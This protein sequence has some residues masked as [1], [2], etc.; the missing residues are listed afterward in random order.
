MN[1][2]LK[3]TLIIFGILLGIVLLD[4]MQAK[5]FNNSPIIKITKT[6]SDFHKKDI[7]ILVETNIYEGVTKQTLFKWEATTIPIMTNNDVTEEQLNNVNDKIIKYFMSSNV[8]YDNL[9]FNY[10]DLTNKKVVVGLYDNSK[11]QQD[12]FRKL[13]V[14]SELIEFIK[15]EKMMFENDY[16]KYNAASK[17]ICL[18]SVLEGL[19][20]SEIIT[21]YEKSLTDII[22]V[23]M[24]KVQYSK[25]KV[26]NNG[27]IYATLKT[28][29]NSIV[30][31]LDNYFKENYDGYAKSI[32]ENEYYVYVYNGFDD[33]ELDRYLNCHKQ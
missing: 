29:D 26:T 3:I 30:E 17:E 16:E 22:N 32:F 23:D 13:V 33:I 19:I 10:V 18:E 8:K 31:T 24:T 12:K 21:P 9:S 6:Y 15:G 5:I 14:D 7:G 25:V 27:W 20:T 11:E 2:N 4:T 28:T 1:K